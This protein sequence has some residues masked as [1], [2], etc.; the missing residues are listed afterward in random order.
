MKLVGDKYE[1]IRQLKEKILEMEGFSTPSQLSSSSLSLGP[2][3]AA[4]P[5]SC[6]PLGTI[7]EFISSYPSDAASTNGFISGLLSSLMCKDGFCLWISNRRT[8]FPPGMKA[9]GIEPHRIIFIDLK[10][11]KDVLWAMELGL[12][13]STLSAVVGEL[14][15]ISFTESQRL[16]LAVEQSK[17]TG[18]IHR[19]SPKSL[20]ALACTTRWKITSLASSLP[21]GMPGVGFPT[22]KVS[23]LKVRN[24]KPGE[25]KMEWRNGQLRP[26][27]LHEIHT[28]IPRELHYA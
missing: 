16:Q 21:D 26:M 8:I 19:H 12:K 13:C 14:Q 4:F 24:G 18:L 2:I 28:E 9:F 5:N 1:A 3:D 10:K 23:L 15:E 25:W 22:W 20:H 11:E 6:F 17:V 27:P 7:H